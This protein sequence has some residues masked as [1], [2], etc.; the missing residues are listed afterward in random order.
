MRKYS[1]SIKYG[2]TFKC[3]ANKGENN[4]SSKSSIIMKTIFYNNKT[5]THLKKIPT[6]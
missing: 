4:I 5:N 2:V 1:I 3:A 6:Q